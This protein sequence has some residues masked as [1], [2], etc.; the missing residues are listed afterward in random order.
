VKLLIVAHDL[1]RG[2]GQGRINLEIAKYAMSQ[3]HQITI[4]ADRVEPELV[5][6]GAT[7]HEIHPVIHRP[8]VFD[9]RLFAKQA[10]RLIKKLGP[11]HDVIIGNGYTLEVPHAVNLCQFV[12]GSWIDSKVHTVRTQPGPYGWYQYIYSWLNARWE[13]R[14]YRVAKKIVAPSILARDELL[15]I[16][17]DGSK[18]MVIP[19]AVD[20]DEFHPGVSSRSS[21]GLPENVV[22]GLFAGDIQTSRKNLDSV[23]RAIVDV[24]ELHLAVVGKLP[25]SP[26]P[27]MAEKLGLTPRVHFLGFRRDVNQIMRAADLFLFPSRYDTFGLVVLEAMATGIP[28]IT[29]SS[30]GA[31]ELMP[32]E[33]GVVLRN[34]D[35]ISDLIAAI[36]KYVSDPTTRTHA[37]RIAREAALEHS[38]AA[39]ARKYLDLCEQCH[40]ARLA[41]AK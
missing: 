40:E 41:V 30:T 37:G 10:T 18:I 20:L 11:A 14:A 38:W 25:R 39:M 32:P 16:G 34:A 35:S 7:W 17:V 3:G 19:N 13:K 4:L 24:P 8:G 33:A 21:L 6:L 36:R 23:L 5:Q 29:A 2:D 22:L 26:Y 12:H 9:V 28:V 31:S 27:A 15:G 1:I